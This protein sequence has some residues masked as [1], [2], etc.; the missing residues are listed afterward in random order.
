MLSL[1][2]YPFLV[3]RYMEPMQFVLTELFCL[4]YSP[5]DVAMQIRTRRRELRMERQRGGV[6]LK[7]VADGTVTLPRHSQQLSREDHVQI[8]FLY[9]ANLVRTS[10]GDYYNRGRSTLS[11]LVI[12]PEEKTRY[13]LLGLSQGHRKLEEMGMQ[14]AAASGWAF[15]VRSDA[16]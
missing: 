13:P 1:A 16:A 3:P 6:L 10:T 12:R 9:D 14:L 4:A 15:V 5:L 8:E 11:L 7:V 2:L